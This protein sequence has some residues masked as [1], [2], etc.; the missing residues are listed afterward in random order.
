MNLPVEIIRLIIRIATCVPS[1]FDTSFEA[2]IS[3]DVEAVTNAIQESMKTKLALCLVSRSFHEIMV[4]YL[5]E[6]VTLR[7]LKWVNTIVSLLLLKTRA[8]KQCRRL[9]ITIGEGC[10]GYNGDMWRW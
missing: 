10:E 5:Y 2:S 4:E 6:I 3:E 8:D 7:D 1:A 9:Q